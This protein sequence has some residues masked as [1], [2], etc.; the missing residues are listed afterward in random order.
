[1][2]GGAP[3]GTGYPIESWKIVLQDFQKRQPNLPLVLCQDEETSPLTTAL[4][5]A[6]PNLKVTTPK[7]LGQ[8]AAFLA[9][10]S[11]CICTDSPVMQLAIA[12][13]TYTAALLDQRS[14]S[15]N[16]PSNDR[17]LV[18]KSSTSQLAD[19]PPSTVLEG[20]WRN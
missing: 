14:S 6:Q 1:V 12:V 18:F 20:I 2:Y 10:A 16:M 19:I 5:A 9:G 13:Q 11:L 17:V 7:T 15:L 3:Q 4:L 8:W